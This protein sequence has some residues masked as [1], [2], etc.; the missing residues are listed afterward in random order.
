MDKQEFKTKA[1]R[2][3]DKLF[4]KIEE[5]DEKKDHVEDEMKEEYYE[6]IEALKE[7]RDHLKAKLDA[8]EDVGEEKWD[9][10]KDAFT[11]ASKSFKV[12]LKKLGAIFD[13]DDDDDEVLA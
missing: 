11:S 10:I 6:K 12:G 2:V 13:D 9:D 8:L 3:I 7:K 4:K 1:N 5:L